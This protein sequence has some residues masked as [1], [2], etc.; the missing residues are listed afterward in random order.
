LKSLGLLPRVRYDRSAGLVGAGVRARPDVVLEG[1]PEMSQTV[2][3][4]EDGGPGRPRTIIGQFLAHR[5]VIIIKETREIGALKCEEGKKVAA[6]T[7]MLATAKDSKKRLGKTFGI[8]LEALHDDGGTQSAVLDFEETEEF[9]NAIQ[10]LYEAAQ[11]L[12]PLKTDHTEA[13]FATKDM[14]KV[15]FY[16]STEQQQ[17]AFIQL[18]DR[19][20][21]CFFQVASLPSF[22]KL[23]EAARSYLLLK[24]AGSSP[25]DQPRDQA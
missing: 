22:K 14:I 17:L 10:F 12:A 15:G 16:Q 23:I 9:C 1:G 19:G 3:D 5:G 24:R 6:E 4:P 21:F 25:A 2:D 8:R 13:T 18:G 7:L 20:D 11:R